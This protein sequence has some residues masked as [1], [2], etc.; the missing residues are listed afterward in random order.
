MILPYYVI[1]VSA[2]GFNWAFKESWKS[3]APMRVA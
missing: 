2:L 1:T 3:T